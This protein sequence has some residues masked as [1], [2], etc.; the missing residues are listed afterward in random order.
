MHLMY[1]TIQ[2]MKVSPNIMNW[3]MLELIVIVV[4]NI[5]NNLA[6]FAVPNWAV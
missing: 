5:F 4:I 3:F 1:A 6:D 2:E